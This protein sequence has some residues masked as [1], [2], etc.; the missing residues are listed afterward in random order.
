MTTTSLF[1]PAV[2]VSDDGTIE[3]DWFDCY[4]NTVDDDD[5]GGGPPR[6]NEP[7]PEGFPHSTLLDGLVGDFRNDP[8]GALRRIA[9]YIDSRKEG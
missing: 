1:Q 5:Q 8:A 6:Y 2:N 7:E 9:D 4:V 3:I